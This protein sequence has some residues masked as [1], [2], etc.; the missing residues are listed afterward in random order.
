[1]RVKGKTRTTPSGYRCCSGG[2]KAI[3]VSEGSIKYNLS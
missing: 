1:M 3:G 2:L